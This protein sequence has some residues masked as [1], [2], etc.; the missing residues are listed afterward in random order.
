MPVRRSGALK[1]GT[2][3]HFALRREEFPKSDRTS[4][5]LGLFQPRP[6]AR[7]GAIIVCWLRCR[8]SLRHLREH[9][10]PQGSRWEG[11]PC[12]PTC[13]RGRLHAT[14]FSPPCSVQEA[15][16]LFLRGDARGENGVRRSLVYSGASSRLQTRMRTP[17]S[18]SPEL[19]RRWPNRYA[20]CEISQSWA[21]S[22]TIRGEADASRQKLQEAVSRWASLESVVALEPAIALAV[23]E[24]TSRGATDA[25]RAG[26]E[27]IRLA[28]ACGAPS[29]QAKTKAWGWAAC[30]AG[31]P[32]A[33]QVL[34]RVGE[35]APDTATVRRLSVEGMAA[36]LQRGV[37]PG[38]P[39]GSERQ[40]CHQARAQLRS[41]VPVRGCTLCERAVSRCERG[42]GRTPDQHVGE[43]EHLDDRRPADWSR[44]HRSVTCR[45][46]PR[47]VTR[48]TPGSPLLLQ[49]L[50]A[51]AAQDRT[52][53]CKPDPAA[54]QD[55][56][57]TPYLKGNFC[58]AWRIDTRSTGIGS[59]RTAHGTRDRTVRGLSS[60][61]R[62]T[63]SRCLCAAT[64]H[65]TSPEPGD[66]I[67]PDGVERMDMEVG[68]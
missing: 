50:G 1:G 67:A 12:Q 22:V 56:K 25:V 39:G 27:A 36:P 58:G 9:A 32:G 6:L 33:Y 15:V 47:A 8:C 40:I 35:E 5:N 20:F 48:N 23:S 44:L 30:F 13:S 3:L 10:G 28:A 34:L 45:R 19:P 37:A 63:L 29:W 21:F 66:R 18:R 41:N 61:N 52:M 26:E 24:I 16:A 68:A 7:G 38:G 57:R 59:D 11:P 31:T 42:P 4:E 60:R 53:R 62:R 43:H 2:P 64:P 51:D 46:K 55:V 65:P 54:A 49:C 14:R 17:A